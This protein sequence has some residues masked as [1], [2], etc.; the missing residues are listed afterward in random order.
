MSHQHRHNVKS[1]AF[2]EQRRCNGYSTQFSSLQDHFI[3]N[4]DEA[5][6]MSNDRVLS[7][8]DDAKM[9]K[10]DKN[11]SDNSFHANLSLYEYYA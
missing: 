4:V 11:V 7:V 10:A 1:S 5:C 6:V 9:K 8:V 3:G 2:D